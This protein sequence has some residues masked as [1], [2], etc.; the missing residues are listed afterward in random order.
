MPA[1]LSISDICTRWSCGRTFVY[2]AVAEM[3]RE[4]YLRRLWLGRVQR[5]E[6]VSVE[7]YEAL[8]ADQRATPER[9]TVVTLRVASAPRPCHAPEASQGGA[10]ERL[11]GY[12][13]ARAR[14]RAG[15]QA[16]AA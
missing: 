6:L 7:R 9:A 1:F 4:G 11:A 8:H 5:V 15:G 2:A 10:A 3:E 14:R 16:R 12:R 13:A